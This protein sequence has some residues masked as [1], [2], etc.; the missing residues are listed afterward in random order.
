[1]EGTVHP[2]FDAALL[3]EPFAMADLIAM[4]P[5][6]AEAQLPPF[7]FGA[8]ITARGRLGLPETFIVEL[9]NLTLGGG[10]SDLSGEATLKNLA[11]P[12]ITLHASSRYLDLDDFLPKKPAK[13]PQKPDRSFLRNV[14]GT[15]SLQV[16]KG[17]AAKIDYTDLKTD[18]VLASGRAKATRLE[19]HALGGAFSGSGSEVD[20]ADDHGGFHLI[21]KLEG[22]DLDAALT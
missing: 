6:V 21:G 15:A 2:T 22:I 7:R 18:L 12:Q 9:R 1:L 11:R 20:L 8:D 19:I 5:S 4:L 16:A 10:A 13:D 17:R 3:V 14:S